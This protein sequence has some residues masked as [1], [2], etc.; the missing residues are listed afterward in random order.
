MNRDHIETQARLLQQEVWRHK[1][2]LFPGQEPHPLELLEPSIFAHV[3]GVE[4]IELTALNGQVFPFK[5]KKFKVAGILDKQSNRIAVSTEFS[6]KV[7]RFTAAHEIGHWILH[8]DEIMHRDKPLDGSSVNEIRPPMER[9]ADFFAGCLLIPRKLLVR[10]VHELF[11]TD[12]PVVFHAT[13]A[14]QIA[15]HS[16]DRLLVARPET[17]ERELALARCK[18]YCNRAFNSLAEIFQ[19]SD[20][21]M[22]LRLK[23]LNLIIWP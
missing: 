20:I 9:E 4:Y 19:V 16:A 12:G 2:T 23:E 3:L 14:H 15:P 11:L 17:L 21:A 13:N 6:N 22:A 8:P 7:V 10:A 1:E 5:G 18:S